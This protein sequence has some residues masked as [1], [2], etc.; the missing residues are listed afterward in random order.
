[1]NSEPMA[2]CHVDNDSLRII[3]AVEYIGTAPE[4]VGIGGVTKYEQ[5]VLVRCGENTWLEL[6]RVQPS[7]KNEMSANDWLNGK[8]GLVVLS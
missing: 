2:W 6:M 5:R 8:T 4:E 7:S 3:E 1:M